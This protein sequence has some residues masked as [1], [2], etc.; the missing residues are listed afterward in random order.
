MEYPL[1]AKRPAYSV[2]SC[3]KLARTFGLRLP[4]WEESL[5]QVLEKT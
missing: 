1:P 3:E 2:L 4:N 5:R